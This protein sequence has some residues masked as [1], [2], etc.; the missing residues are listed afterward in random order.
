MIR[1]IRSRLGWRRPPSMAVCPGRVMSMDTLSALIA[2]R[3]LVADLE[4]NRHLGS[5][6]DAVLQ[7]VSA[8]GFVLAQNDDAVGRDPRII[9]EAPARGTYI[10]R[11]FAFPSTPDQKD[12][13]RRG[14]R[15]HLS[16]HAYDRW[17]LRARL[18]ARRLARQPDSVDRDRSQH[19][20]IR[21]RSNCLPPN[22]KHDVFSLFHPALPGNTKVRRVTGNSVVEVEP[23]DLAQPQELSDRDSISG[24]IDPP[25][26]R[27][28]F[29]INLKKGEKHMFSLESR[30]LGLPLDAVLQVL[31]ADGKTLAETD[32]VGNSRD[33][34]LAFTPP[35]D[36]KYRVVVRD[37]NGR[38]GPQYAYLLRAL[39]PEPDFTL[40]LSADKFDVSLRQE[41]ECRREH[42]SQIW[43]YRHDR[44]DG[45][46]SARRRGGDDCPIT[47][48]R[49]LG[50]VGDARNPG[51]YAVPTRDRFGSSEDRPTASHGH[52][53]PVLKFQGLKPKRIAL[54]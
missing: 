32:D 2:D 19:P 54:G 41:D 20:R 48:V 30:T 34:E 35:A 3:R 42:R 50:K 37:F 9:F 6:M 46:G 12:S 26:D 14:R 4:A 28:V 53:L 29:R 27:D 10:V 33:P 52:G 38:G 17:L 7:V 18:P 24:T 5:P 15:L 31:D 1:I 49:C 21:P 22:E 23:N 16:S 43:V 40:S 25:G 11:L 45:R 39:V 8:D 36:G 51:R 13:V 47:T 44:R